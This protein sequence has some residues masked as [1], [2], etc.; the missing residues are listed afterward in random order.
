MLTSC[1]LFHRGYRRTKNLEM[2]ARVQALRRHRTTEI[3]LSRKV[4]RVLQRLPL[5]LRRELRGASL[6]LPLCPSSSD[7][8]SPPPA[9]LSNRKTSL[10]SGTRRAVGRA[11]ST[12]VAVIIF[13]IVDF[14][15]GSVSS[16]L[17]AGDMQSKSML[18]SRGGGH[19][20]PTYIQIPPSFFS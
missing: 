15:V 10:L 16:R 3:N 19:T 20:V 4:L 8:R 7:R 17:E 2:L 5:A 9:Q 14:S 18:L 11:A 13:F 6:C 1:L 12:G